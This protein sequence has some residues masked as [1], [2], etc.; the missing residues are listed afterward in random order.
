M[1]GAA[2]ELNKSLR[3]QGWQIEI[4][5]WGERGP[6]GG[7]AQADINKDVNACEVLLALVWDR[8][9]TPT[10][11][12]TSGFAEEWALAVGRR[13]RTGVPDL[14]LYFKELPADVDEDDDQIRQVRQFRRAIA[15][16]ET[17]FYKPFS[18]IE[19]FTSLIR[20]RLL[21]L[22]LERSGLTRVDIGGAAVD[23]S[24][25]CH[26]D[27]TW[28]VADGR[29][30]QSLADEL[31]DNDPGE[32]APLL[33]GLADDV[34]ATGFTQHA[35]GLRARACEA[36]LAAGRSGEAIRLL[37]VMLG[38]L[39]WWMAFDEIPRVLQRLA[40]KLPP[41]MATEL[42]AWGA[43]ARAAE[44]PVGTI[45]KLEQA[46]KADH[47][48][49]LD[50]ESAGH[51]RAILWRCQLHE[52]QGD[53]VA[54][55]DI[56]LPGMSA[57]DLELELAMLHADALRA[58]GDPKADAAW[59][60]LRALALNYL[61]NGP[62]SAAW[63]QTRA[64]LDLANA[65]RL[66]A[67]ESGYADVAS[68]W[69]HLTGRQDSA[70]LCFFSAQA[71]SRLEDPWTFA[72]W[73]MAELA[74]SQ[75]TPGRSFVGRAEQ[76][77]QQALHERLEGRPEQAIPQLLAASWCH[78]RAGLLSGILKDRSLLA[79]QGCSTHIS[80]DTRSRTPRPRSVSQCYTPG[81]DQDKCCLRH[82]FGGSPRIPTIRF[83]SRC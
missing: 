64:A 41:E 4:K 54:A 32:A 75:R 81:S 49:A 47:A 22:A 50:A 43:C 69:S 40:E 28:L 31:V 44:D 53:A 19:E 70:A 42:A 9:G 16:K 57:D 18:T 29:E 11:D 24:A 23:W 78:E 46:L 52:G 26:E 37:R 63:I 38:Q 67:A 14:W 77:E 83:D 6:A 79:A 15:E 65:G 82:H 8:W 76:L 7:R 17:A 30:R 45:T 74:A 48:I 33:S 80:L 56:T 39:T 2:E 35:R 1:G 21:T 27:P 12:S 60:Q 66:T 34:E 72:G 5:G 51:L 59:Q 10:G 36:Y 25:A 61:E 58:A 73:G 68:R 13:D 62:E 55:E 20:V 3:P 71:A